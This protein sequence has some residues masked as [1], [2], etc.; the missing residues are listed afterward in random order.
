MN[1]LAD[2]TEDE[3]LIAAHEVEQRGTVYSN[4]T[5]FGRFPNIDWVN[6]LRP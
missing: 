4:D 3:A 2:E 5:D 6:P 1:K